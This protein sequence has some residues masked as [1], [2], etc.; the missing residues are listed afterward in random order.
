MQTIVGS[1]RNFDAYQGFDV[2]P[3]PGATD[4]EPAAMPKPHRLLKATTVA[5]FNKMM[6]QE[7]GVDE[8]L[9][10]PWACVGRQN[11]TVRPD[12]PLPWPTMTLEECN[13]KLGTKAP[14]RIWLEIAERDSKTGSPKWPD[15]DSIVNV[16]N[17]SQSI[18]LFLKYFDIDKQS[19][20]GQ[21]S[22]YIE[23][24]K[25]IS[26]LGPVILERMGWPAGTGLKL[27]EVCLHGWTT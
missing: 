6:S 20:Y 11:H 3:V 5:Q 12:A 1:N 16:K 10:R 7:L 8:D 17:P 4:C 21:G 9:I 15:A 23:K 18:L 25:K 19:L 13:A 24:S 26:E 27:Y 22:V 2:F 14:M